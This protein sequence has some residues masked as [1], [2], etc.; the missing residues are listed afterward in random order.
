MAACRLTNEVSFQSGLVGGYASRPSSLPG[1]KPQ[2]EDLLRFTADSISP[3]PYGF[4][5]LELDHDA[6]GNGTASVLHAR[7]IFPD[8][9]AFSFP[10]ADELPQALAIRDLFS[11][12]LD[13]LTLCLTVPARREGGRNCAIPPQ[14]GGDA[15]YTAAP[16]TVRDENTGVDER[17]IYFG[18]KN[19]RLA[20]E[21][22][23][24]DNI[25]GLPFARVRRN[26]S[27]KFIFDPAFIPP[28]TMAKASDALMILTGGSSRYLKKRAPLRAFRPQPAQ[29]SSPRGRSR[30][31]GS[32]TPS[33]PLWSRFAISGF[34]NIVIP[35]SYS[36][37][38][39]GSRGR[40]A[41]LSA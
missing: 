25:T 7:G 23:L 36:L 3:Y 12:I 41:L 1:T 32:P 30:A 31:S 16:A 28:C 15:R 37:R 21:R 13:S 38:C 39:P 22:E 24:E 26:G 29:A 27:G 34:P 6:I 18:Q 14:S 2:L 17:S 19:I 40:S 35:K 9:L 4:S 11:P 5:G 10:D 8:G 33:I 20:T